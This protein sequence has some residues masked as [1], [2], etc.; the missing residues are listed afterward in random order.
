[1]QFK[2]ITHKEELLL[3]EYIQNGITITGDIIK[4]LNKIG[5]NRSPAFIIK[6]LKRLGIYQYPNMDLVI[7]NRDKVQR[8]QRTKIAEDMG[9]SIVNN[10]TRVKAKV[11]CK[12]CNNRIGYITM[13][14]NGCY[15]CKQNQKTKSKFEK[16]DEI[17]SAKNKEYTSRVERL[18]EFIHKELYK[19]YTNWK[20]TPVYKEYVWYRGNNSKEYKNKELD[21]KID[22]INY[23]VYRGSNV[24]CPDKTKDGYKIC[25]VCKEHK[26]INEFNTDTKIS[27]K[28]K[29]CAKEYRRIHILPNETKRIKRKI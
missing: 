14:S 28:C 27:N 7:H 10:D 5:I 16:R 20:E 19:E 26:P 22:T 3:K 23:Y 21:Y 9:F 24:E 12:E 25:N 15:R 8:E 13:L 11:E 29:E 1:M 6:H 17:N 18:K 2:N 4:E